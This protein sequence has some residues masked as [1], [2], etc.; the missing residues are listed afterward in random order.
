[1]HAG[2]AGHIG[3]LGDDLA[4]ELVALGPDLI[5]AGGGQAARHLLGDPHAGDSRQVGQRAMG[6]HRADSG[7]DGAAFVQAEVADPGQPGGKG[8][9]VEDE[10]RLHE[11]R[12][13]LDLPGQPVGGLLGGLGCFLA[14][15]GVSGRILDSAEKKGRRRLQ[16]AARHQPALVAHRRADPEEL[17]AVEV[18]DGHGIRMVAV[19]RMVAGHDDDVRHA[20][21]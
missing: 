15:A 19:P 8:R 5:G 16:L 20:E 18:E 4:A 13:G 14:G 7:E 9:H 17:C 11:L 12:A 10:L 21:C 3:Q 6:A 2:H 1:M